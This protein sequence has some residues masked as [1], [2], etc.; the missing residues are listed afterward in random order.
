MTLNSYI[1]K[2]RTHTESNWNF[3]I[4]I[5]FSLKLRDFLW[6]VPMWMHVREFRLQ[7]PTVPLLAACRDQRVKAEKKEKFLASVRISWV[8]SKKVSRWK[9]MSILIKCTSK[10]KTI[11]CQ[12]CHHVKATRHTWNALLS[13]N[14]LLFLEFLL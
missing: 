7:Q 12:C 6:A 4:L 1:S 13:L 3:L 14:F 2:T 9:K 11:W 8:Y 5:Q 10:K